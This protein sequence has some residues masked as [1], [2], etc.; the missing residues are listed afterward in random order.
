MLQYTILSAFLQFK[1]NSSDEF[2]NLEKEELV[3][4]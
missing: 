4:F 1:Q 3:T 2:Y